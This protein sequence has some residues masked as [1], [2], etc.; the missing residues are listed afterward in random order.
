MHLRRWLPRRSMVGIT[1]PCFRFVSLS[2]RVLIP[3]FVFFFPFISFSVKPI[4]LNALRFRV[5]TVAPV[6]NPV[7]RL[8]ARVEPDGRARSAKPILTSEYTT[9]PCHVFCLRASV[10]MMRCDDFMLCIDQMCVIT[11]LTKWYLH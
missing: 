2:V 7:I 8:P 10:L 11:V 5:R 9:P 6:R 4:T 1:N 3:L